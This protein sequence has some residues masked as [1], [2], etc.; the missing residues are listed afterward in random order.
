MT[1]HSHGDSDISPLLG[2]EKDDNST[3]PVDAITTG[4]RNRRGNLERPNQTAAVAAAPSS[5]PPPVAVFVVDFDVIKG[6]LTSLFS[7]EFIPLPMLC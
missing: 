6:S 7:A 4:L 1:R 3:D 2:G 5:S